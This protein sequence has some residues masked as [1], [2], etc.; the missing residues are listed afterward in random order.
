MDE[1][2]QD[3]KNLVNLYVGKLTTPLI[4]SNSYNYPQSHHAILNSFRADFEDFSHFQ[5][6]SLNLSYRYNLNSPLNQ[7]SFNLKSQNVKFGGINSKNNVESFEDLNNLNLDN[8][9]SQLN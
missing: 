1:S 4:I 8:N 7:N 3:Q 2:Y 9:P 5:D 6:N